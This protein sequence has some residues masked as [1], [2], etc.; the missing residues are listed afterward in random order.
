MS[1]VDKL[2]SCWHLPSIQIRKWRSMDRSRKSLRTC[3]IIHC[4]P[5]AMAML[6]LIWMPPQRKYPLFH[7][8]PTFPESFATSEPTP[9]SHL[10]LGHIKIQVLMAWMHSFTIH[11]QLT[12]STTL[13]PDE[14]ENPFYQANQS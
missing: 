7:P 1:I 2:T 12:P 14:S 8:V 9:V 3:I 10:I 6:A 13:Q 5:K 11:F 4:H